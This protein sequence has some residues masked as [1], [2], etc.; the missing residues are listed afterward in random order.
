MIQRQTLGKMDPSILVEWGGRQVLSSLPEGESVF[1]RKILGLGSASTEARRQ[2]L[3]EDGVTKASK[4]Q[5]TT[6]YDERKDYGS[7]REEASKTCTSRCD[8][9]HG[10]SHV[11]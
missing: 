1:F 5:E 10:P 4:K 8:L 6:L 11:P 2:G 3:G 9:P 7:L